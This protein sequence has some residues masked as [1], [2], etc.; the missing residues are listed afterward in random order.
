MGY[1]DS[2]A[3]ITNDRTQF[4]FVSKEAESKLV[5]VWNWQDLFRRDEL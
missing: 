2:S 5:N 1:L 4:S 3:W